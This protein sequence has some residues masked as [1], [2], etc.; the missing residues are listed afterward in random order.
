VRY[1]KSLTHLRN[2]LI[3]QESLMLMSILRWVELP[4]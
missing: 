3:K 2:C 4:G 1:D